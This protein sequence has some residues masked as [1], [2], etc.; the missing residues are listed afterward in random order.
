MQVSKQ[1]KQAKEVKKAK[2]GSEVKQS[3]VKQKLSEV[4]QNEMQ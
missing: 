2:K 1:E 4:K 3:G